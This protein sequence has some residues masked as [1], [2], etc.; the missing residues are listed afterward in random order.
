MIDWS[1]FT[2]SPLTTHHSHKKDYFDMIKDYLK[3]YCGTYGRI[4]PIP[5]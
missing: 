2:Y 5:L 1:E 3:Q 4:K